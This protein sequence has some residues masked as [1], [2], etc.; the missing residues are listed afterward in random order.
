MER[1]KYL[2]ES[3]G[4]TQ[5]ELAEYLNKTPQAYSLYENKQRAPD[6]E[7]LKELAIYFGVSIDYLV[8]MD[9]K[10]NFTDS[11]L[12]EEK[13]I[14]QKYR[15]LSKDAKRRIENQLSFECQQAIKKLKTK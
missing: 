11:L 12:P 13:D 10:R 1:L 5:K 6:L 8:G 9:C 2:R 3:S 14:I 7:T 15:L 4:K